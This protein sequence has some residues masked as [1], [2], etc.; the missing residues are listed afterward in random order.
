MEVISACDPLNLV[1]VLTPGDR[2]PA[3]A[4]NRI[5]FRDGVPLAA[6]E[7]GIVTGLS[8]I[9]DVDLAMARSLLIRLVDD[10]GDDVPGDGV[11]EIEED[12]GLVL[13]ELDAHPVLQSTDLRF[14]Y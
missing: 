3:L 8:R 11:P 4:G 12:G 6:L 9:D 13:P 7:K 2:V 1:G 14:L 5:V 10:P